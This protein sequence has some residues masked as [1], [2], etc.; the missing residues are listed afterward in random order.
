MR[1]YMFILDK[2]NPKLSILE[3][4]S[5]FESRNLTYKL[6]SNSNQVAVFRLSN[7]DQNDFILTIAST[8]KFG[9][10]VS[11]KST[12][13]QGLKDN[14]NYYIT[15]YKGNKDKQFEK[16]LKKKYKKATHKK[17]PDSIEFLSYDKYIAKKISDISQKEF[18]IRDKK[19]PKKKMRR[20]MPSKLAKIMIN[21][22]KAKQ[23]DI[24]ADPFA[25]TGTIL[26]E[27]LLNNCDVIG[28][29]ISK[30]MTSSTLKNLKW[31]Y[32]QY[33]LTQNFE[34]IRGD[35]TSISKYL[36]IDEVDAMVTEPFIPVFKLKLPNF[37]KAKQ[38][39][40][41]LE[42]LYFL[43][44]VNAKKALK[45]NGRIVIIVPVILTKENKKITMNFSKLASK[46]NFKVVEYPEEFCLP[47]SYRKD[48]KKGFIREI[49]ILE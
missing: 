46:A 1:D 20:P 39:I 22:S 49:Y 25:G 5:Y 30:T 10:I 48:I 2:E 37:K 33:E 32:K 29:D 17:I 26:Q 34:M 4:F 12:L 18:Q 9:E 19:K 14:F 36:T 13:Y 6:L 42:R 7:L 38:I 21:L 45:D 31:L 11:T 28:I 40:K 41:D 44:L 24:L 15:S 16:F 8:I 43:F 35:S 23:G 27:A 47:I 3:L